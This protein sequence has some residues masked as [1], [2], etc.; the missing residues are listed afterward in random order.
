MSTPQNKL[1]ANL[2]ALDERARRVLAAIVGDHIEVGEPV[3]SLAVQRRAELDVSAATVRS[4]MADLEALG[5]LEKPHTSAGRI[6]TALGYRYYVD[7]LLRVQAPSL[8]ER[9]LIERSTL[10]AAVDVEGLLAGTS[11]LLRG[12]THH[13]AVVAAPRAQGQRLQRIELVALREGRVLAVLMTRAGTVQN[14]LLE[15]PPGER[16]L[17]AAQLEESANYL[18]ALLADLTL[19]EAR[20]RLSSEMV[21]DRTLLEETRARA[22]AMGAQAMALSPGSAELRTDLLIEGQSSFL[23][24]PIWAQDVAKVRELFR[25]LEEKER[26]LG[27]LDRAT[28]AR[29][30]CIFIGAESGLA[31]RD[32]AIVAAPYRAAEGILGTVGVIGPARM[33]YARVIPLVELTARSLG[34]AI[35]ES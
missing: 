14:R 23:E 32:L 25:A 30:L 9:Q 18:N 27:V 20:V 5:Y 21:R 12:L 2:G 19:E 31:P 3:G 13:A 1:A 16:P 22:L 15:T 8:E 17:T 29:E 6:P 33:D 28:Q 7:A 10:E 11:R 24:E 26:V 34:A 4:V 35:G